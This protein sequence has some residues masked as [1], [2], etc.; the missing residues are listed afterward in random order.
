[1][2][3]A[4]RIAVMEQGTLQ[5]VDTPEQLYRHPANEFVAKFIGNPTMNFFE[6]EATDGTSTIDGVDYDL[7]ELESHERFDSIHRMAA[8]PEDIIPNR[9]PPDG[10]LS[11]RIDLVEMRGS[12]TYLIVEHG[13]TEITVLQPTEEHFEEGEEV[14]LSFVFD[15]ISFFDYDGELVRLNDSETASTTTDI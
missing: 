10:Q 9:D 1:M 15:K 8:R 3:L 4:D 11:G 2:V 12:T 13:G 7:G 14:G 6:I 5:Q